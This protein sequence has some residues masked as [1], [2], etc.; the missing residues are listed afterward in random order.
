MGRPL[1]GTDRRMTAAVK[2]VLAE[3]LRAGTSSLMHDVMGERL[4][5]R[6]AF[7]QR[8]ASALG[9][10][11]GSELGRARCVR[12]DRPAAPWT[13]PGGGALRSRWTPITGAGGKLDVLAQA[14]RDGLA[15]G[16][17][18]A[19]CA[20]SR[21]KSSLVKRGA[22]C[23]QGRA[24]METPCSAHCVMRGLAMDPTALSSCSRPGG[25]STVSTSSAPAA[26]SGSVPGR[27]TPAGVT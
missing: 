17:V 5:H 14:Q 4:L 20:Q 18:T 1:E 9:G 8:G 26:C 2:R 7:A 19:P 10:A 21:V 23:G 12:T 16:Q 11:L 13:D 25:F 22:P 6:C 15:P 3:P 27:T 24:R